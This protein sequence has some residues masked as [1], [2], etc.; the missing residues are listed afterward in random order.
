VAYSGDDAIV[1]VWDV[2]GWRE[3]RRYE[4]HQAGI[5]QIVYSQDSR[6]SSSRMNDFSE[7][8]RNRLWHIPFDFYRENQTI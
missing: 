4:G 5:N 8:S 2:S 6:F 7:S 3:I 1:H